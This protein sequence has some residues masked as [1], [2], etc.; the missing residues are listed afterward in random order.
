[1]NKELII[2]EK[3]QDR[4]IALIE[5]NKLYEFY[6]DNSQKESIVNNIYKAKIVRILEGI[7]C[8]FVE[9]EDKKYA[10]LY[11]KDITFEAIKFS[12]GG[13]TLN[14]TGKENIFDFLKPSN[15][16]IVQGKR[17]ALWK[18][19]AKVTTK[20][21]LPS[22]FL[23]FLPFNSIVAI[24]RKI[25]NEQARNRL[26]EI[27]NNHKGE[28]GLIFR[29]SAQYANTQQL[30]DEINKM[31]ET[32]QEITKRFYE[33][34]SQAR[35]FQAPSLLE[36][37]LDDL[38]FQEDLMHIKTNSLQLYKELSEL[39]RISFPNLSNKLVLSEQKNLFEIYGINSELKRILN[40]LIW[41]KS[42]GCIIINQ[43]EALTSIDVNTGKFLG[44][45]N[46]DESMF[47][48]NKE[49]AAEICRQLRLRNISGIIVIDFVPMAN[50]TQYEMLFN[51]IK[52]ELQKDRAKT[53]LICYNNISLVTIIRKKVGESLTN[54]FTT[55]CYHCR[56]SGFVKSPIFICR[57]LL[58]EVESK[59]F[60]GK[61]VIIRAH[62]IVIKYLNSVY[63]NSIKY[64][65]KK[66]QVNFYLQPKNKFPLEK[67]EIKENG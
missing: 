34:K 16:L 4:E 11:G 21:A 24:S 44:K 22:K 65:E 17:D 52:E 1:M 51:N 64:F 42:G 35:I 32:W 3:F 29:T 15:Y 19:N 10:Y 38:C 33:F 43:T 53:K 47:S 63:E 54:Y 60:K 37:L 23:I 66:N 50:S 6:I 39:C 20:I 36:R 30:I 48:L 26:K 31:K 5:N 57:E 14:I 25:Q 8:C 7:S 13:K 41:L 62:P 28:G 12:R 45:K 56:G 55:K 27:G 58:N 18:K 46:A 2:S 67:Y 9:I 49:A 40:P 61:K 59:D